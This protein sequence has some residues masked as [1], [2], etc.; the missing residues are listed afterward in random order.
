MIIPG[1]RV[2]IVV[3][4]PVA[5]TMEH[6]HQ[7]VTVERLHQQVTVERL[8]QLDNYIWHIYNNGLQYAKVP[9]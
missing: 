5:I 3:T 2:I 6:L 9:R 4:I 7:Q 8:H 1:E